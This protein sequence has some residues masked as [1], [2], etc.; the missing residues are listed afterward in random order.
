[1]VVK[2]ERST[3]QCVPHSGAITLT[4]EVIRGDVFAVEVGKVLE[5]LQGTLVAGPCGRGY[6]GCP[7]V[8]KGRIWVTFQDKMSM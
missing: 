2:L 8:W 6:P 7:G 3:W 1:M 5:V 4:R